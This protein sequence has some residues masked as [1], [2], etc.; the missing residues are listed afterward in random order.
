MGHRAT[1]TWSGNCHGSGGSQGGETELRGP[2]QALGQF[3]PQLL[4]CVKYLQAVPYLTLIVFG[5]ILQLRR[6][7][8]RD[9][10]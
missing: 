5:L 4:T 8:L 3:S 2:G 10:Q 6:L 7:R 9:C 1:H